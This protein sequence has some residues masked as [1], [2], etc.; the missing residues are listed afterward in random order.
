MNAYKNM[1]EFA[2]RY[3]IPGANIEATFKAYTK[4]AEEQTRD[5]EDGPHEAYGGGKS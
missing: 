3:S 4:I 5:P 1:R 2:K